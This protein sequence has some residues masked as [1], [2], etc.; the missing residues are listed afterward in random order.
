M[1]NE[2][3]N[4]GRE[5][6]GGM[7]VCVCVCGCL[8]CREQREVLIGGFGAARDGID[9]GLNGHEVSGGRRGPLLKGGPAVHSWP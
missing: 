3:G 7:C 1:E 6:Q 5:M 4:S 8:F 2:G 9:G